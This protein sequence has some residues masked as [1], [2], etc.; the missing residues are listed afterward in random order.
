MACCSHLLIVDEPGELGG[1]FALVR[2]AV[3]LDPVADLVPRLAAGDDGA[4]LGEH[5]RGGGGSC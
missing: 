4:V 1:R 3:D 2:G 5:C